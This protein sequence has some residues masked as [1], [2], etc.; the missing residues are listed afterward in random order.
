MDFRYGLLRMYLKQPVLYM[1]V[2]LITQIIA[3]K[4]IVWCALRKSSKSAGN[5]K[6]QD[7]PYSYQQ[8]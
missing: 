4:P 7:G 3:N 5:K 2:P 8:N 1:I 6:S